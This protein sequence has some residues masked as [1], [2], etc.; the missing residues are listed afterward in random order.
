MPGLASRLLC[1]PSDEDA[2]LEPEAQGASHPGAAEVIARP[3]EELMALI[4]IGQASAA[5]DVLPAQLALAVGRPLLL[6]PRYGTFP[7]VADHV[8]VAWNG[9]REATRAATTVPVLLSH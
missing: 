7:T 9:S 8:L 2:V 1:P 6:V 4:D 5:L 3:K